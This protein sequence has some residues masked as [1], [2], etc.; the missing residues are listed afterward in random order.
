MTEKRGFMEVWARLRE[1]GRVTEQTDLERAVGKG[2]P[3]SQVLPLRTKE[4]GHCQPVG[5]AAREK[6]E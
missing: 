3:A 5:P 6:R 4:H 2:S 1:Q